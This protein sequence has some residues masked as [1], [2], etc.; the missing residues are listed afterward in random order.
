MAQSLAL[1]P[2]ARVP[3]R[4]WRW[5]E[6]RSRC[7]RET[8]QILRRR[9]DAEEAAQDA[10]LRAWR[11][12]HQCHALGDP[13][14]WVAQ[15]ARNEALRTL[16]KRRRRED[17]IGGSHESA[18][19]VEDHRSTPVAALDSL[20]LDQS[21][22]RLP[23]RDRALAVLHYRGDIAQA[24]LAAAMGIPEATI[25]VRLHRMRT[26]LKEEMSSQP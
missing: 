5:D 10:L 16:D 3:A 21:L 14:P 26:R 24:G 8:G 7:L 19:A 25:R 17:R 11:Q 20:Q 1:S 12:R 13:E 18:I 9:E 2:V 6:L 23:A 22:A 15:I 4:T